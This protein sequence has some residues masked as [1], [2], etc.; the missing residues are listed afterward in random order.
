MAK[1]L[2]LDITCKLLSQILF[3]PAMLIGT[4]V[5]RKSSLAE[6]CY[7]VILLFLCSCYCQYLYMYV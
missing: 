4:K 2:A 6:A 3:V 5:S 7:F 1:I